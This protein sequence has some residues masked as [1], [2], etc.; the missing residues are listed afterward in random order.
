[1]SKI[2]V[3][4]N[5][6]SRTPRITW[7]LQEAGVDYEMVET[8][9]AKVK[10]P[11]YL[12]LNPNGKVPCIVDGDLAI[13]ESLAINLYIAKNYGM[14]KIY[15]SDAKEEALV[16][17]WTLWVATEVEPYLLA[18]LLVKLGFS[19]DEAAAKAAPERVRPAIMVLDRH[20]KDREWL[21][22]KN[23]SVADLNVA[24]VVSSAQGGE[25]DISYAKNVGA[26]LERC[27]AR[28]AN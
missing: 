21:V 7:C 26:W 24:A 12:A 19:K 25:V 14:G 16:L 10:S 1:M 11:E 27:L 28:A 6:F 9:Y 22:G 13:F 5:K 2:R 17:Q 3:Y 15:P 18:A 8:P 23:F 4:G 20:L